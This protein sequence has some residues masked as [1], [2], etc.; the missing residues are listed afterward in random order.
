[1][2]LPRYSL[3]R[4]EK[5]NVNGFVAV[6]IDKDKGSQG[7]LKWAI[8][9]LLQR[10]HTVFLIHVKLKSPSNSTQSTFFKPFLLLLFSYSKFD[11]LFF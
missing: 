2:W 10:G 11:L 5:L 1:M 3:E 9:H 6:A 4:K 8:D 7:A